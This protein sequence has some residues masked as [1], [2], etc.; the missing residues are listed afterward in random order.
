[1]DHRTGHIATTVPE[2]VPCADQ[3]AAR[4]Q[5]GVEAG[6]LISVGHPFGPLETPQVAVVYQ[7][8]KGQAAQGQPASLTKLPKLVSPPMKW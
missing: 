4:V 2:T 6:D 3:G 7:G 8:S 5:G 1:M